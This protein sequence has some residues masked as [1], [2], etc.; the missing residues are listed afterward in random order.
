VAHTTTARSR[1]GLRIAELREHREL[2]RGHWVS[3]HPACRHG[4]RSGYNRFSCR[5]PRC[6]RAE[7]T[8]RDQLRSQPI[9]RR[10][11][12]TVAGRHREWTKRCCR[13]AAA[14]YDHQ[15]YV[16]Q[17]PRLSEQQARQRGVSPAA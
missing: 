12:G 7:R 17:G 3:V 10:L 2:I 6:S 16:T 9:P 13:R 8:Y 5:C 11:H 4:R 14:D 15:R 1:S